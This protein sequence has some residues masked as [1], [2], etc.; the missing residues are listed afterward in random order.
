MIISNDLHKQGFFM[1][2]DLLKWFSIAILVFTA[3]EQK[4]SDPKEY[5]EFIPKG[6][7]REYCEKFPKDPGVRFIFKLIQFEIKAKKGQ[8]YNMDLFLA[9]KEKYLKQQEQGLPTNDEFHIVRGEE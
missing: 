7:I 6:T 3:S 8:I 4:C 2:K 5:L 1:N 9:A